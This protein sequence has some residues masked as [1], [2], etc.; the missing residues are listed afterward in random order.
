MCKVVRTAVPGF[1]RESHRYGLLS[2]FVTIGDKQ[3]AAPQTASM[4]LRKYTI[5]TMPSWF[6][7]FEELRRSEA[8]DRLKKAARESAKQDE[9]QITTWLDLAK[10][11]FDHDND[12]DPSAA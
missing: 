3:P 7:S 10:K 8:K 12:P 4:L 9:S 5:Y 2:C 6:D 11:M 1:S